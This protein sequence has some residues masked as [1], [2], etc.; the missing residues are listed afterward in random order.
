MGEG[1]RE[2]EGE[3]RITS[4]GRDGGRERE[5]EGEKGEGRDG[6]EG[7]E[8]KWIERGEDWGRH[9]PCVCQVYSLKTPGSSPLRGQSACAKRAAYPPPPVVRHPA[10]LTAQAAYTEVLLPAQG[11]ALDFGVR[12][13]LITWAS[14][15]P[16]GLSSGCTP[17]KSGLS[18]GHP[19]YPYNLQCRSRG[20][21]LA[22]FIQVGCGLS[23]A[24]FGESFPG[25]CVLFIGTRFSNLS[26][27][28]DMPAEAA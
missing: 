12:C 7:R 13:F 10:S 15:R 11:L 5:G 26:I 14:G 18:R 23:V 22:H 4:G 25:V 17:V 21:D 6:K 27:A 28:V 1:E 20:R 8:R 16:S 9:G 19:R 24:R 3:G 2:E